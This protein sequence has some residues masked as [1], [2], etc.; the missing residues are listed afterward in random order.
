MVKNTFT[1]PLKPIPPLEKYSVTLYNKKCKP[2]GLQ[3]T[4]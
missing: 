4:Q 1:S 3:K 2:N